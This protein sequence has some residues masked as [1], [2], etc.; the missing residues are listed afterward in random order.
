[1]GIFSVQHFLDN[2][3]LIL[4]VAGQAGRLPK[5]LDRPDCCAR[6]AGHCA[7]VAGHRHARGAWK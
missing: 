3:Y 4:R 1:M 6:V 5:L 7:R 2:L